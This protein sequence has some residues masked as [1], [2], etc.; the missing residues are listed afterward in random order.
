MIN[1]N[2]GQGHNKSDGRCEFWG[3]DRGHGGK[4]FCGVHILYTFHATLR[5]WV[6]QA[7]KCRTLTITVILLPCAPPP[8]RKSALDYMHGNESIAFW[9]CSLSRTHEECFLKDIFLLS[10]SLTNK[11]LLEQPR[12]IFLLYS[13][14]TLILSGTSQLIW[15]VKRN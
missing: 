2:F 5:E 14:H 15:T 7:Q 10:R 8:F 9:H 13:A 1:I 3:K 12:I 6:S 4:I 11:G